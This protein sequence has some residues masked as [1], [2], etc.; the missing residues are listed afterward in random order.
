MAHTLDSRTLDSRRIDSHKNDSLESDS[1]GPDSSVLDSRVLDSRVVVTGELS[2]VYTGPLSL[3][4]RN[5]SGSGDADRWC[6]GQKTASVLL[7][8][9]IPSDGSWGTWYRESTRT[10][11]EFDRILPSMDSPS[12]VLVLGHTLS[13]SAH[14]RRRARQFLAKLVN[15][16]RAHVRNASIDGVTVN[17]LELPPSASR[18]LVARRLV[19][20]LAGPALAADNNVISYENIENRS[21]TMALTA[22]EL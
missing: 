15:G 19:R 13:E 12:T 7:A 16:I 20:F 10:K 9:H 6:P 17:G 5:L 18:G 11:A 22:F 14:E 8:H 1:R 4:F 2:Q 3:Y 21:I